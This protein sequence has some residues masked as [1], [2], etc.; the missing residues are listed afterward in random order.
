MNRTAQTRTPK[1]PKAK[2]LMQQ[3]TDYTSEGS[4]PPGKVSTSTPATEDKK[5]KMGSH[6]PSA[7]PSSQP[8]RSQ[9]QM[10]RTQD[11]T[12]SHDQPSKPS[13]KPR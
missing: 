12:K 2:S 9:D 1:D 6:A 5:S 3:Q 11:Q 8:G 13:S 7:T 4:P 10:S